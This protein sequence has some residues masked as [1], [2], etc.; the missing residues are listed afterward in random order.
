[1]RT[2]TLNSP[3]RPLWVSAAVPDN[4]ARPDDTGFGSVHLPNETAHFFGHDF[5]ELRQCHSRR[6]ALEHRHLEFALEPADDSGQSRLGYSGSLRCRNYRAGIDNLEDAP[7][8][9]ASLEQAHRS[10]Q[11]AVRFAGSDRKQAEDA[12]DPGNHA[13]HPFPHSRHRSGP[14]SAPVQ[15][16]AC[17]HGYAGSPHSQGPPNRILRQPQVVECR[18]HHAGGHRRHRNRTDDADSQRREPG[19][20][21]VDAGRRSGCEEWTVPARPPGPALPLHCKAAPALISVPT[22]AVCRCGYGRRCSRAGVA[23]G[24]GGSRT[25][26]PPCGTGARGYACGGACRPCRSHIRRRRTP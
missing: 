17:H 21:P 18:R 13:E 14:M 26:A 15:A 19:R 24:C 2:A 7:H 11:P 4:V 5:A 6:P 12:R 25:A 1:M 20:P 10:E 8:I 22:G 16:S 23:G 3:T 9:P